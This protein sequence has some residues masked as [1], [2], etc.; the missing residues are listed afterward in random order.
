MVRGQLILVSGFA[1]LILLVGCHWRASNDQREKSTINRI[2]LGREEARAALVAMVEGGSEGLPQNS[3]GLSVK[4]QLASEDLDDLKHG[5]IRGGDNRI[6]IS[7]WYCSLDKL[8]FEKRINLR[9]G[10]A[11]IFSGVFKPGPRGS[12]TAA[13]DCVAHVNTGPGING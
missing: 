4:E 6:W 12:W 5:P 2:R 1:C 3:F 13:I 11:Y 7:N 10:H 8:K 9:S